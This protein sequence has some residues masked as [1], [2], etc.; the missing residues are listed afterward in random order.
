MFF[1]KFIQFNLE[2]E[3]KFCS[4]KISLEKLQPPKLNCGDFFNK[5]LDVSVGALQFFELI[6]PHVPRKVIST[7]IFSNINFWIKTFSPSW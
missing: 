3:Q 7:E 6:G 2:I 4:E 5:K 1:E